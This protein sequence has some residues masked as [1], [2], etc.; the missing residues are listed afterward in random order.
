V[1]LVLFLA[2][3]GFAGRKLAGAIAYGYTAGNGPTYRIAL[4]NRATDGTPCR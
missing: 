4:A 3:P 1:A 2:V